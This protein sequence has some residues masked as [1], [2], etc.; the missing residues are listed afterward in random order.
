MISGTAKPD[1]ADD[2]L[3]ARAPGE[4]AHA[5][6]DGDGGDHARPPRATASVIGERQE[7][8]G[9]QGRD[10]DLG[11]KQQRHGRKLQH[12]CHGA[13]GA[14]AEAMAEKARQ[15]VGAGLAQIRHE[16]DARDEQ[17]GRP[18]KPDGERVE[19]EKEQRAGI[20]E[21]A[22]CRR[23]APPASTAPL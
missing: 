3:G 12:A 13:E 15:R 18:G 9:D 21:E 10:L 14:R 23:S 6:D 2:E 20:G 16:Q 8:R 22:Q 5:A 1:R 11:G 7:H 4:R 17:A 19:A